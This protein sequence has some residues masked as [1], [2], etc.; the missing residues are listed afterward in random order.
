MLT[1]L[2]L[3]LLLLGA[4]STNASQLEPRQTANIPGY[5]TKYGQ[6]FRYIEEIITKVC[7]APLVYLDQ[8]E[9]YMPSDIQ[10]QLNNTYPALNYTALPRENVPSPLLLS[11]LEQLNAQGNCVRFGTCPVFLTSKDNVTT[12][13]PWLYG[14]TPDSETGETVGAKSCAIIVNDHGNGLVD[15]I[16][17]YFYAFDMGP[18]V[19][20]QVL[21]NHVGDWEHSMVRFQEGKPISVWLSQHDVCILSTLWDFC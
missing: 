4:S 7:A 18:N 16:Y 19:T 21:G 5:V 1:Q 3:L 10:A 8:N 20:G 13:P 6:L 9:L 17:M 2:S 11:D 12:N 15:A 14:V